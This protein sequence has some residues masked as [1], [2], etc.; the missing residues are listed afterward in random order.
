MELLR[1]VEF[2]SNLCATPNLSDTVKAKGE[3]ILLS[4]IDKLNAELSKSTSSLK[5]TK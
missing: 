3:V 5:L 1:L 2:F 4:L